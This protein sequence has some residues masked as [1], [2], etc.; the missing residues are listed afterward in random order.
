M[1]KNNDFVADDSASEDGGIEALSRP[2]AV[3]Q[4]PDLSGF[5]YLAA[6]LALAGFALA[7]DPMSVFALNNYH[8]S[9]TVSSMSRDKGLRLSLFPSAQIVISQQ[10][11]NGKASVA[12]DDSKQ[13]TFCGFKP[14]FLIGK[15]F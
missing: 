8:A 13:E 5:S 4:H 1:R 7:S 15:S 3:M 2:D 10:E 12:I 9:T 11:N 6:K 14:G